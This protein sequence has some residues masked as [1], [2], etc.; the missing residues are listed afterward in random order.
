MGK[1]PKKL[2][3]KLD[4]RSFQGNLRSLPSFD[5]AV[6]FV[7]NDYLGLAREGK[8]LEMAQELLVGISPKN[9]STGSRLL[10]GNHPLYRKVED[11]L[12]EWHRAGAALVFNSGFDANL[13]FFSAVPQ[14]GDLVLY[15]ELVHA[16][17]RDGIR[18]GSA[19]AHRFAHNDLQ[20]LKALWERHGIGNAGM[21]VYIVT[22]SVF[23]MD[24]DSP[25]LVALARFCGEIGGHL[26][27]DEAHAT[28]IYGGGR[29]LVTEL[30]LES[31]VFARTITFGKALGAHG[32][33]LLGSRDLVEYLV[34]FA[35][36]LI[37][38]TALPPHALA[39]ILAAYRFLGE[40][41]PSLIARLRERIGFFKGELEDLGLSD[42]FIPSDS[43]IQSILVPGNERAGRVAAELR[44]H[45][46]G[47]RPIL[48]PTVGE[49]RERLRFCLHVHNTNGEISRIL[50]LLNQLVKS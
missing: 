25:D 31:R 30:G 18:L 33:A 16:S 32:A 15:D 27:V 42:H 17:I 24:G 49:G 13:G 43:A 47:I 48:S 38:S 41:A 12:G 7:S 4:S 36:P 45:G 5:G 3:S 6:D 44:G 22:E 28:G 40:E 37:Y 39:G 21:E 50:V 23:S 46:F 34:N 14:R 26:V 10:S 11:H 35:R 8:V 2:L 29:D 1:L 9:G 19:K 20:D